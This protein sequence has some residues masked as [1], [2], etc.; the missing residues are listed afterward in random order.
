MW[1][2]IVGTILGGVIG[3]AASYLLTRIQIR[4]AR[5]VARA[6][7][8]L[9][10]DQRLSEFDKVHQALRPGGSWPRDRDHPPEGMQWS[11]VEGYMG[12]F[13]RLNVLLTDRIV[14]TELVKAF[15]EYRLH[16]LVANAG[17]QDKLK[18]FP[19]GWSNFLE[20][21]KHLGIE[22]QVDR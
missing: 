10:F 19:D 4:E 8:L 5:K 20:L 11:E 7:L 17:I 16:N 1:E 18:R 3:F 13:E 2:G 15:Y 9:G 12:A 14:S 21:C 6:Q 22:V